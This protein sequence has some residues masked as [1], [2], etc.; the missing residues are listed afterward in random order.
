MLH[1]YT[2]TRLLWC[3][4]S[5]DPTGSTT[6]MPQFPH[7]LAV[8]DDEPIVSLLH[9]PSWSVVVSRRDGMKEHNEITTDSGPTVPGPQHGA[10]SEKFRRWA[11]RPA[12]SNTEARDRD[13]VCRKGEG[14]I[15]VFVKGLIS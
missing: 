9:G 8:L 14:D 10:G 15:C 1:L 12:A 5:L 11:G 2:S 13:P 6:A 7:G 4:S 3:P